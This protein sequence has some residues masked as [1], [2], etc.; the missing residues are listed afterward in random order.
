MN[1]RAITY[2]RLHTIPE[3]WAPGHGQAMVF[4]QYG[5]RLRN[6]R[7][8]HPQPLE[9]RERF[10]GEYLINAQGEDV[11]AGIRTPQHLT[12]AEQDGQPVQP[13]AMEETMPEC[14]GS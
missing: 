6:R 14:S 1:P 8:L 3:A 7:R 13:A 10:Y 11:V 2:R 12:I 5:R 4:R 9:R